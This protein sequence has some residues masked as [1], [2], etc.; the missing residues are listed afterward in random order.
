MAGQGVERREALR[1]LALASAVS[2]CPGFHRWAFAFGDRDASAPGEPEHA[3][4]VPRFFTAE[5]YA[6]VALLASLIIPAD[7]TPGAAEAGVSEFVDT[8]VAHDI[9]L[10]PRFRGALAW[11]EAR[12]RLRH[13]QSFAALSVPEQVAFLE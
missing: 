4:Y 10:Q 1:M 11:I 3:V 8:M 5:E 7:E 6:L 12:S 9:A 13:R 2:A